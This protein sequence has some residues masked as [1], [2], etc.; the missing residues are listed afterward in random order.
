MKIK[1]FTIVVLV[2]MI[3]SSINVIGIDQ[4]EEKSTIN[5]LEKN[6]KIS[7]SKFTTE[8]KNEYCSVGI[9]EANSFIIDPG[10]PRLPVYRKIFIFKEGTKI[11]DVSFS[12]SDVTSEI[13][14]RKIE[15]APKPVPRISVKNSI[16][17]DENN[18]K[19]DIKEKTLF[20]EK[21]NIIE[22]KSIYSSSNLYP[23]SWYDYKIRCGLNEGKDSVFLMINFYPVRYSPVKNI[24]Y[25]IESFEVDVTYE[26]PIKPYSFDEEYELM[27][28]TPRKFLISLVPLYFHKIKM[29]VST[30]IKT[31]E[32]IYRQ[33]PGRDKP[34]QIKYF[35]KDAKETW[36]I[37]YVLLF[38]GLKTHFYANDKDNRNEGSKGWYVPVRY[39]NLNVVS[40]RDHGYI[41]DLYYADIYKYNETS[42]ENEFEDWD[43]NG[44]NIFL[45]GNY[46]QGEEVDLLPDIYYGRIPVR[47]KLEAKNQVNKII[48]Y[49]KPTLIGRILGKPWMKKMIAA[50]GVTTDNIDYYPD[51]EWLCDKSIE[52]MSDRIDE[53]VKIYASNFETGGP[54]PTPGDMVREF[55][56]GSGFCLF[57][58]H[59]S[60]WIWDTHWP[61]TDGNWT[62]GLSIFEFRSLRNYLMPP[63]LVVGGCH[64]GIFNISLL[65]SIMKSTKK[66]YH[67]Y[68]VPVRSCFSWKIVN[69][70]F[71]G[72][73]ASTGCTS[74]GLAG[75]P[76]DTVSGGLE[77]NFFYKIGTDG[78][79]RLGD[80]HG[81]SIEKYMKDFDIRVND[82][83]CITEYELFGDPSLKIGGY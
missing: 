41:S 13:I 38:G 56:K 57:Q 30:K 45:D 5:I 10:K 66:Y 79:K 9:N 27:I 7:F 33:Y 19:T 6:H 28:I 67:S 70:A 39:A 17:Q 75:S 3:L 72:A 2:I 23:N 4:E 73:I 83:F 62:G 16:E 36:N 50:G 69:K 61:N 52:Y 64:N 76:P 37:T 78:V 8:S 48:R 60:A 31:V 54:K 26:E 74:W 32:S 25:N 58:G 20:N 12:V 34:E 59:G 29:G 51:G 21:T 1:L 55:S 15:P 82:V 49:E 68:G 65:P 24:V 11:N 22:D 80:A 42:G 46:Y 44:N 77:A 43:S 40:D 47:N 71:G 53:S 18:E 81:G 63:I 35:I 14:D